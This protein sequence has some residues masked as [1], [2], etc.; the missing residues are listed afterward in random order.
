MTEVESVTGEASRIP[1]PESY[2]TT[3]RIDRET[4][5]WQRSRLVFPLG[6]IIFPS[7]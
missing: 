2:V 1:D 5:Q 6:N 4:L 7:D 3:F